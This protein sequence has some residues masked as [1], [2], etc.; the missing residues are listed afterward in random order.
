MT[1]NAITVPSLIK[2]PRP[3]PVISA[4]TGYPMYPLSANCTKEDW[5][6]DP[7]FSTE[8]FKKFGGLEAVAELM[9]ENADE[10]DITGIPISLICYRDFICDRASLVG[11]EKD[12]VYSRWAADHPEGVPTF[13]KIESYMLSAASFAE[14]LDAMHKANLLMEEVM[15]PRLEKE[16]EEQD[17]RIKKYM[18]EQAR[19]PFKKE[20]ART[21][22]AQAGADR[23][24]ND[25]RLEKRR[26]EKNRDDFKNAL[27][28]AIRHITDVEDER[29]K[30]RSE[31]DKMKKGSAQGN[32]S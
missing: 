1:P 20:I 16:R 19:A 9:R 25:L 11:K 21:K 12:E 14:K 32:P 22:G 13:D 31:L 17:K 26:V 24:Y 3:E 29:D 18:D 8:H 4:L 5:L 6:N 30:L 15:A 28:K 2:Q 27:A 23:A 10:A 7:R